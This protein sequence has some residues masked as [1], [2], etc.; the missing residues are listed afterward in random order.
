[1]KN[2][3]N[4]LVLLLLLTL[5]SL[6]DAAQR[7]AR[8]TFLFVQNNWNQELPNGDESTL[9][10][11]VFG[12]Q[13]LYQLNPALEFEMWG[14]FSST[15]LTDVAEEE[16]SFSTLNDTR[17]RGNYYLG[18]GLA[19]FSLLVNLPTGK[20]GLSNEE[21]LTAIAVSDN[22]RKFLVRRFGEGFDIGAEA[23]LGVE[24]DVFGV[25]VEGGYLAKGAYEVLAESEAD[26]KFGN[27]L[28]G[29]GRIL[30]YTSKSKLQAYLI[31]RT[32][33]E[34]EF[35]GEPIF[36][37]GNA[38]LLGLRLDENQNLPFSAG[39]SYLSRG[40]AKTLNDDEKLVS[41]S[42]ISARNELSLFGGV[43]LPLGDILRAL[44]RVEYKKISANDY[45]QG[46]TFFRPEASYLGIG[47]G[48]DAR[49][50]P[51]ASVTAMVMY[52]TGDEANSDLSGLGIAAGLV[53]EL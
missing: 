11:S 32:F 6:T 12:S 15:N 52:F 34:D 7:P 39:V 49:L 16:S 28:Y 10:E 2:H 1:M 35:D 4:I 14:S 30:V 48:F 33:G 18:N 20:T 29:G 8:L 3:V 40:K 36:Q 46:E 22:A 31:Y 45:E 23:T 21:Y 53:L 38:M 51:T 27:E 24:N 47:G 25:Q 19:K 13:V 44:G 5:A 41:E 37:A 9:G 26:Y 17:L 42:R 50:A 43:A